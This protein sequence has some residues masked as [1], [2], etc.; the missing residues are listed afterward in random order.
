MQN[1]VYVFI[2][3]ILNG[4]LIGM[5]FDGFRILRKSFK[6]PDVVTY[7][8]DIIFSISSGLLIL[9]SVMK[10]NNGEIRFYLFLGIILGLIFYL[11]TFS[12][13]F[14]KVSISIIMILKK[15]VNVIIIIPFK[16]I[17]NFFRKILFKPIV[18]VCLN[19]RKTITKLKM[20]RI[21]NKKEKLA[22]NKL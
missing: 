13:V 8:E 16:Y 22:E 4:I 9:F 11:L 14:I 2:T 17:Y 6:T 20:H 3:F 12:R 19:I 10:F 1:Q 15:V 21:K 7:V 5:L 18:F